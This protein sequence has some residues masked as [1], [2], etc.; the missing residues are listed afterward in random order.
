LECP[1]FCG[2]KWIQINDLK[3]HLQTTCKRINERDLLQPPGQAI[4]DLDDDFSLEISIDFDELSYDNMT[5]VLMTEPESRPAETIAD[6][7]IGKKEE[8]SQNFE[9]IVI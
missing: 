2:Y 5:D 6:I 1:T 7:L 9:R 8:L 4:E 3:H